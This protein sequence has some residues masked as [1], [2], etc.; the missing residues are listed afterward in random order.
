MRFRP[1]AQQRRILA[2]ERASRRK[3]ILWLILHVK[4]PVPDCC[5]TKEVVKC[6]S[7]PSDR[8]FPKCTAAADV[9][10]AGFLGPVNLTRAYR[11]RARESRKLSFPLLP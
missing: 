10:I 11:P 1:F 6:P 9:K 8:W 7:P 3:V 4:L 5:G 2:N